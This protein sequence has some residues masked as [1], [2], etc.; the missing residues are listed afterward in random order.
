MIFVGA[1]KLNRYGAVGKLET[2]SDPL[3]SDRFCRMF[4]FNLTESIDLS[5]FPFRKILIKI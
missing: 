3:D 1:G 2:L 4:D 5:E